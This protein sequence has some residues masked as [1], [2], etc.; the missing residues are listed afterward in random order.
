M[1]QGLEGGRG[2]PV[3]IEQHRCPM[4]E[5]FILLAADLWSGPRPLNTSASHASQLPQLT[6]KSLGCS[7]GAMDVGS[8][9]PYSADVPTAWRRHDLQ[10]V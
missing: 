7:R 9:F 10:A 3:Q 5:P 6:A 1:A 4:V 2:F 8:T